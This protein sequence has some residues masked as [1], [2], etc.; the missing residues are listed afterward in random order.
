MENIEIFYAACFGFGLGVI[1]CVLASWSTDRKPK[2]V[3]KKN[4]GKVVGMTLDL[5]PEEI[6]ISE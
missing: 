1:V 6:A 5:D 4:Y 3:E 2:V